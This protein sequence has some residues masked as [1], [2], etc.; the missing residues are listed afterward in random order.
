[1]NIED[2]ITSACLVEGYDKVSDGSFRLA[3]PFRYPDGSHTDLLLKRNLEQRVFLC[4]CLNR[5]RAL[6]RAI[7]QLF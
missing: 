1:M 3:T 4:G 5:V 6:Q 2:F 7:T